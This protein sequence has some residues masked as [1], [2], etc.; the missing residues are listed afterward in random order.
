[1]EIM[2]PSLFP[3]VL[4]T[5][6]FSIKNRIL[7][8]SDISGSKSVCFWSKCTDWFKVGKKTFFFLLFR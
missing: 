7:F 6:Q 8:I 3:V 5:L 1:M 4:E 2:S